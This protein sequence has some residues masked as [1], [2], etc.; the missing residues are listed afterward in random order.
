MLVIPHAAHPPHS[1][2]SRSE[3]TE[4]ELAHGTELAKAYQLG[5][6]ARRRREQADLAHKQAMKACAIAALPTHELQVEAMLVTD[7]TAPLVLRLPTVTPPHAGWHRP[8]SMLFLTP[9]EAATIATQ[10]AKTATGVSAGSVAGEGWDE[11]R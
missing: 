6:N 11:D 1:I 3:L 2:P 8:D 9:E 10:E 5:M 7:P 4:E